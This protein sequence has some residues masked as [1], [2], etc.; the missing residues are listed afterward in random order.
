MVNPR[1]AAALA[2]RGEIITASVFRASSP[3]AFLAR[4]MGCSDCLQH[5]DA[6][7][8]PGCRMGESWRT[9]SLKPS[10]ALLP[11]AVCVSFSE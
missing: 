2:G 11:I 10:A 9:P 7:N 4:R 1:V 3:A 5:K 6:A 8:L